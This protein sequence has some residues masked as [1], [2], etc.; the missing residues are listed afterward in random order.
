MNEV[1]VATR[2]PTCVQCG[3]VGDHWWQPLIGIEHFCSISCVTAYVRGHRFTGQAQ[4]IHTAD[5]QHF[6]Q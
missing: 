3:T 1:S 6:G 5:C 2:V 4:A